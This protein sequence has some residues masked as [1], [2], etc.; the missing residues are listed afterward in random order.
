ME[1]RTPEAERLKSLG[2]TGAREAPLRSVDTGSSVPPPTRTPSPVI[3]RR[4][5]GRSPF[6]PRRRRAASHNVAGSAMY[7]VGNVETIAS[8]DSPANGSAW[9]GATTRRSI[10]PD[11]RALRPAT[12]CIA[13][14]GSAPQ[15]LRP[16]LAASTSS[17]PVPNPIS[18]IR[19]SSEALP[20]SS[21]ALMQSS[22]RLRQLSQRP[23]L[24]SQAT[25]SY[26][27][28]SSWYSR[29]ATHL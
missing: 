25:V 1:C 10:T 4:P 7:S 2:R 16:R 6:G 24:T 26:A 14:D 23:R 11:L 27:P 3:T 8:N 12:R 5:P 19:R 22:A 15:A 18:S 20:S 13:N 9:L 21:E 29:L 17:A 28:A